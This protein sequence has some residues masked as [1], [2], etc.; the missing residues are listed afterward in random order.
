MKRIVL[1]IFVSFISLNL[2]FAQKN[3]NISEKQFEFNTN[4]YDSLFLHYMEKSENK[5]FINSFISELHTKVISDLQELN[6]EQVAEVIAPPPYIPWGIDLKKRKAEEIDSLAFLWYT[7]ID[8]EIYDYEKN[9]TRDSSIISC[10]DSVYI[11]RLKNISSVITL[12]YNERVK[13]YIE[14]YTRRKSVITVQRLVGRSQYYF[15]IFEQIFDAYGV[16]LELKYLAIIE[17][18]LNPKA[19]SR[20]S[21]AGLWQFIYSTGRAY[22]MK[23]TST[24]DERFDPI[25]STHAAAR[26]LSNLYKVYGDWTLALAAYNCGPGNVNR[27][28][29]KSG[30]SKDYWYISQF[31][32]RETRNYVPAYIGAT[33]IMNYYKEHKVVP[34]EYDFP[35]ASDT[36]MITN[37]QLKFSQIAGVLGISTEKVKMLNPQ[38][39]KEYIPAVKEGYALRLPLEYTTEFLQKEQE[40]YA[41]N[42][43]PNTNNKDIAS[44]ENVTKAVSKSINTSKQNGYLYYTVKKG[45]SFWGISQKFKDISTSDILKINNLKAN[46]RINPG[47]K[48]KIKR[49]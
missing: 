42:E 4:K 36:L 12:S 14:R 25:K 41:Y 32:P 40:I 31:L 6:K 13:A 2:S 38:Y 30:G 28:I 11:E 27:A 35:V 15:P 44:A 21:A 22:D 26:Y 45:D 16:P 24:V 47:D 17:S 19:M 49:I 9:W 8:E 39:K 5:Y 33:Y 18:A 37:K 20:A 3:K 23:I 7:D 48:I 1:F 46:S 34:M 10:S 43:Q 29:R